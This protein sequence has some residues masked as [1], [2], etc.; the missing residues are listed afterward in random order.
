MSDADALDYIINGARERGVRCV[1]SQKGRAIAGA[2][3]PGFEL[4]RVPEPR[5]TAAEML[6]SLLR[7]GRG[8]AGVSEDEIAVANAGF[9]Q[10]RKML[11]ALEGGTVDGP[12]DPK[13]IAYWQSEVERYETLLIDLGL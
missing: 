1:I 12:C 6:A 10:A 4:L 7:D 11:R 2:I 8:R 5:P 13:E 3:P 9:E